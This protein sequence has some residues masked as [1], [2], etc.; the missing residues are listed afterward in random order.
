MGVD[1]TLLET[2]D[3]SLARRNARQ[4]FL[5]RFNER[6]LAMSPKVAGTDFVR[7]ASGIGRYVNLNKPTPATE[8]GLS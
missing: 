8:V 2:F 3:R 5:D 6:F 1:A 4:D 7:P